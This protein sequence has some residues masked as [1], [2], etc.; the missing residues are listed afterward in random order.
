MKKLLSKLSL[1][2]L[3]FVASCTSAEDAKLQTIKQGIDSATAQL[4]I[5]AALFDDDSATPRSW[6]DGKYRVAEPRDWTSGFFPGNLWLAYQLTGDEE[7]KGEALKYTS[8]LSEMQYF[9]GT[10]DLGFMIFCSYGAQQQ[11]IHDKESAAVIVE[12]SKSLISRCDPEIGLIRSWDFGEWNYPVI[13]DNMMNLE[14]LFWA[15]KH[16]GNNEFRDVAMRHADIT[17]REHFREDCSSYHVISY[18]N[19]GTVESRGTFQGNADDSAWARGQGWGL[20]GYTMAYR[21]TG[22]KRYFDHAL[23]IARLVTT[24]PNTPADLIPYWDYDVPAGDSTPRDASAAAVFASALFE[25]STMVDEE[26]SKKYFDYAETIVLNLSQRP[27]LAE[28]GTNGGFILEH[29][30]GHLPNNSEIDVPLNYADYY[31]LEAVKRY[32]ELR[33]V[34]P[35]KL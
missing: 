2:S 25:L 30:T 7:L 14:M 23:K 20:Y 12:A 3:L 11:T 16:S 9:K 6:K 33:G 34:N 8:R 28:V 10:H 35:L 13:I 31:Y 19:D 29:S 32:L 15:S 27:Y 26:L 5:Q 4:K 1:C 22:E 21:E 18:N 24:H 17:M